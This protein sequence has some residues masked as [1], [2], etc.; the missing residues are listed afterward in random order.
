MKTKKTICLAVLGLLL[1][2]ATL[3]VIGDH[4]GLFAGEAIIRGRSISAWIQKMDYFRR[5]SRGRMTITPTS[6]AL[7]SHDAAF[8]TLITHGPEVLPVLNSILIRSPSQLG[9]STDVPVF[10]R[11]QKTVIW[12][13]GKGL[14]TLSHFLRNDRGVAEKAFENQLHAGMVLVA[15]DKRAG[16]GI[17]PLFA[18]YGS[19]NG[20]L[21]TAPSSCISPIL[22]GM[23]E[24]RTEMGRDIG[25]FLQSTNL[26]LQSASLTVVSLF[27]ENFP[28]WKH[29]LI[30]LSNSPWM[31]VR[32]SALRALSLQGK[33]DPEILAVLIQRLED[34]TKSLDERLSVIA[35]L[36][37]FGPSALPYLRDFLS[38]PNP[39]LRSNARDSIAQ[40]E[41]E[42]NS[43]APVPIYK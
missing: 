32:T 42:S 14:T 22:K 10:S 43:A 12:L 16:G 31:T 33:G 20:F 9:F 4:R 34:S 39:Y 21:G 18:F 27:P 30:R 19:T 36:G 3:L 40:I 2:I 41:R 28:I 37:S 13:N 35:S 11:R 26:R 23:P 6:P 8:Q 25:T 29:D 24:K 17:I 38:T 7:L 15:I 5:D 1:T